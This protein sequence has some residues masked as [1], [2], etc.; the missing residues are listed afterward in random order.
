MNSNEESLRVMALDMMV[1]D[2]VLLLSEFGHAVIIVH[3]KENME[4]SVIGTDYSVSGGGCVRD[5]LTKA[6]NT[7]CT[8]DAQPQSKVVVN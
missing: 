5:L 6:L 3:N 7:V 4:L 1:R 2:F 8:Q